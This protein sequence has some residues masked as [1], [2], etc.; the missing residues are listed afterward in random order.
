MRGVTLLPVADADLT[1]HIGIVRARDRAPNP[2]SDAFRELLFKHA[3]TL[4]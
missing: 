4:Q 2:A 3:K 1:R